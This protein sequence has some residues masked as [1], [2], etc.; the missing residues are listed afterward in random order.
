MFFED[1]NLEIPERQIGAQRIRKDEDRG[2]FRAI[3]FVVKEQIVSVDKR[4]NDF[5]LFSARE[6]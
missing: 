1:G 2:A 3:P 5:S 4:Q 6:T